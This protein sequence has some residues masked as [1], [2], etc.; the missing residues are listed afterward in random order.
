MSVR[1][2]LRLLWLVALLSPLPLIACGDLPEPFLGNPGPLGRRLVVPMDSMYAVPPPKDAL[3]SPAAARDY[4]DLIALSLQGQAIPSLPRVPRKY[5]WRL[6]VSATRQGDKVVP[7]YAI[8]DPAGKEQGAID[9]PP[10]PALGWSDGAPAVL[11]RAADE[12]VPRVLA[13]LT[14]IHARR[15]R[16]DPNSLMNRAAKLYVPAVTGAPGDGDLMLTSEIRAQLAQLGPLV[17]TTPENADFV[18]RGEVSVGP[19]RKGHQ[20]V[21]ITWTVTRPSGALS[22]KVSQLNNVRAGSLDHYWGDVAVAVAQ[23]AAGGINTVVERFIGREP[24]KKAAS[25][26]SGPPAH[27]AGPARTGTAGSTAA[28]PVVDSTATAP[29]AKAAPA[30]A[31]L[32]TV[33]PA[34]PGA[35]R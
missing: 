22:G 25:S 5:D 19:P 29:P 14:S 33:P 13:L 9:G 18:I 1:L 6:N 17:Q 28:S 10:V 15:D 23:E 21:E 24:E 3:M 2:L 20:P 27:A 32:A 35:T 4:A 26:A 8:D 12:A 31:T 11:G 16:A 30:T 34:H 7:R